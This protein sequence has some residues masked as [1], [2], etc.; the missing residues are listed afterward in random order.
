MSEARL[1]HRPILIVGSNGSG[2]TLLRLM[3]DSHEHIA[4]PHETGFLRLAA[5]HQ[6]V[7]YWNLGDQ[8]APSL[9]LDDASLTRHL[10]DFYGGLF[11]SY[12]ARRGKQRWGDKTAFHLWHLS[13]AAQMFPDL[14]IVGIV[15][16]PGAVVTSVRRRFRRKLGS[17]MRSWRRSTKVLLQ[18]AADF[19]ERFAVLRYEDLVTAPEPTM[20]ALLRWLGE[21]WSP[22]VIAH[23]E[24]ERPVAEAEGF[25]RTDA[26]IDTSRID[27]WTSYLR[28]AELELL[29]KRTGEYA[30]FMGYDPLR[31][32]PVE[33]WGTAERPLL[34]G[35]DVRD[36]QRDRGGAIDWSV[37]SRPPIPDRPLL[38][39]APSRR[40][41]RRRA[42]IDLDEVKLGDVLRHRALSLAHRKLSDETRRRANDVRRKNRGI[43]RIIGPR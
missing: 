6:W 22:A 24:V 28:G 37:R 19:G 33:P 31:P 16:H 13:L 15:R 40:R 11:A 12:A 9:D 29:A 20:R 41:R 27:E 25:T 3:L 7:P 21:P 10:A 2:T 39:P 5:M 18:Q 17:A 34:T 26:P 42:Q 4:I 8:W 23:H 36:R 43:D 14:Q 30:A 1:T 35:T 32:E 38:P